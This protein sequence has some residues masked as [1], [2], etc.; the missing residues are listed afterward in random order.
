MYSRDDCDANGNPKG[1]NKALQTA[2]EGMFLKY[3]VDI[4]FAG[5]KHSAETSWPV[6]NNTAVKSYTNPQYPVYVIS[7]AAGNTEVGI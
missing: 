6:Y 3:G 2:V 5:H 7:G 4:F 1:D